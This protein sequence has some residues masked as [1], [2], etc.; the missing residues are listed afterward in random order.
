MS[1]IGSGTAQ[2]QPLLATLF[3]LF[4]RQHN[5]VAEALGEVNPHWNDERLFQEARRIVIAQ[6]QMI[7]YSHFL[8]LVIGDK[9]MSRGHLKV[10]PGDSYTEYNPH[11]NPTLANEF[12][13]AVWRFGHS[14]INGQLA[15]VDDNWKRI[16]LVPM[17]RNFFHPK[18]IYDGNFDNF[19]R[20]LIDQPLG[21]FDP[22]FVD[23]IRNHLYQAPNASFGQDLVSLNI[24]RGRDHG[25]RGY[26]DYIEYCDGVN[27]KAFADLNHYM[28]P[29]RWKKLAKIYEH[30]GDIDMYTGE[31]SERPVPGAIVGPTLACLIAIQFER[32][33]FGDRFYFEHHS[34]AGTFTAKQLKAIKKTT[35]GGIVCANGDHISKVPLNVFIRSG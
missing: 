5:H 26:I 30:P 16:A 35:L 20:G 2:Q 17:K 8:P 7:S 24:K 4:Y 23:D 6:I 21:G 13:S 3:T 11:L 12:G 15:L 1:S 9:Y 33:K 25:V 14:L 18:L 22:M 28:V 19:L 31:L 32:L 27:I 10:L 29:E 34:Q